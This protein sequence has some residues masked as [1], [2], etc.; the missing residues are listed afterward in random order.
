MS[1]QLCLMAAGTDPEMQNDRD[2]L[3]VSVFDEIKQLFHFHESL[4]INDLLEQVI[5]I[6]DAGSIRIVG[7]HGPDRCFREHLCSGFLYGDYTHAASPVLSIDAAA[8]SASSSSISSF[9]ACVI[10][11]S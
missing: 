8:A 7:E 10:S 11:P 9:S 1:T 2:I 3:P 6:H 4:M 5:I